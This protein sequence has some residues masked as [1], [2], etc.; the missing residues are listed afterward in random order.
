MDCLAGGDFPKRILKRRCT[1]VTQLVLLNLSTQ[2]ASPQH[3]RPSC[4]TGHV[5]HPPLLRPSW[6]AVV[7]LPEFLYK[8]MQNECQYLKQF[9]FYEML[10]LSISFVIYRYLLKTLKKPLASD[11]KF[12][13]YVIAT[14]VIILRQIYENMNFNSKWVRLKRRRLWST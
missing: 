4:L 2:N 8:T 10:K 14:V 1:T 13:N 9:G 6:A 7:K 11:L 12:V 3:L 5:T